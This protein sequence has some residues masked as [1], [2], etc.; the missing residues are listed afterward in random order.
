MSSI[1]ICI[2]KHVHQGGEIL[3]AGSSWDPKTGH[4]LEV[5]VQVSYI[6]NFRVAQG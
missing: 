2:F 4:V 5:Y 6:V 3:G 1:N